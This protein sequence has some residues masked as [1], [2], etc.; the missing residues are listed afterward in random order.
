MKSIFARFASAFSD[1]RER[2]SA[3]ASTATVFAF[4]KCSDR[5]TAIAPVPVPKSRISMGADG[6]VK[7]LSVRISQSSSVSGRGT[8][9]RLSLFNFAPKKIDLP[10][11]VLQGLALAAP[12]DKLANGGKL[13]F[14]EGLVEAQKQLEP[15]AAQRVRDYVLGVDFRIRN[16]LVRE[17]LFGL[18]EYFE[19]G[20]HY[21]LSPEMSS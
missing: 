7:N 4:G 21:C 20:E 5:A 19:Y 8:K 10:E 15:L 9:A 13:G 6:S 14:V 12:A 1:A 11:N 18:R 2:A 16:A 3:L 17:K